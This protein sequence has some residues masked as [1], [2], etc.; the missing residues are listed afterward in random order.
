MSLASYRRKRRFDRTPEPPEEQGEGFEGF[1]PDADFRVVDVAEAGA[2]GNQVAEDHV[3]LEAD[4]VIGAAGE[5]RF[6]EHLR[7]F[8]EAGGRDEAGALHGRL[9][10]AQ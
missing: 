3:L 10:D 6:G 7:G 8:L 4:E 2:G 9:G 5:G 1:G